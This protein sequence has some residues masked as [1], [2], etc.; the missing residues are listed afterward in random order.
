[1][2]KKTAKGKQRKKLLAEIVEELKKLGRRLTF[3]D[4][5]TITIGLYGAKALNHPHGFLW[6]SVGYKLARSDSTL[7]AGSGLATLAILGLAGVPREV[8]ESLYEES[9]PNRPEWYPDIPKE[10][11]LPRFR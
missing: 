10:W 9:L 11:G 7:A 3:D 1:L 5:L 4:L 2:G 8:W 6:G